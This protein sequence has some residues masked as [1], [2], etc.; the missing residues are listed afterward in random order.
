M[1]TNG[2]RIGKEQRT[3]SQYYEYL[4][5]GGMKRLFENAKRAIAFVHVQSDSNS[6]DFPE[7]VPRRDICCCKLRARNMK[8]QV[9]SRHSGCPFFIYRCVAI[10]MLFMLLVMPTAYSANSEQESTNSSSSDSSSVSARP[11]IILLNNRTS[12]HTLSNGNAFSSTKKKK[13]EDHHQE[14][15][16]PPS[17]PINVQTKRNRQ[18]LTATSRSGTFSSAQGVS[19]NRN[20]LI[21]IDSILHRQ[22]REKA[23]QDSLESIKM[24]ILMRLNLKKLPNITKPISVPQNILEDFYKGYNA[25]ITNTIWRR[26]ESTGEPLSPAVLKKDEQNTNK[27][28]DLAGESDMSLSSQMQGDDA[29][30][31]NQFKL[32]YNPGKGIQAHPN[33]KQDFL[34][35]N[36]DDEYDSILSHISSIYVFPEQL[37][38][39]VRHN[40]KT[41]VLRFKFDNSYSDISYATL[42]LYLRGWDWISTHQP[43]LIEEIENQQSKDIVVAIHRAV[44]RANNTSFTHKAKMFEFR[45][46]I[47]SGQGQ[48]VNVDLKP[49]FG[50]RGSNKSHEILIKG[51]ESWM[52]PLVV[53]TDNTSNNPLTVHIEIGS[54]KKHR[55]KRSV[56][57]DCTESDHDMRCC[58][59]PLKVNFTSF[60]WHFVV[61]PTSFDAYFCSGDCRV[62]YLEQYPHTHLAAL[63][64]SATP[65]CSPTKMSSLS[66][67]YFDDNHNLV[68]SVIPN[69]SVEG[70]SCS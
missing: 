49:V 52:K 44:R 11:E 70:C 39:H 32:L 27:S 12:T 57:M 4:M 61:A 59:Y 22:L 63:T 13:T 64:T 56:Y 31:L 16:G 9:I 10:A 30:A 3:E 48:W 38:P 2:Y 45:Q 35:D 18:S 46:K 58:R 25:S 20:T 40:R 68:L 62:G 15:P 1:L 24:H 21:N 6:I 41:D 54:Q 5:G 8:R 51:V 29:N 67:L 43:E 26:R 36:I 19:M 55:R 42:H 60:G 53:T 7:I 50:D 65:C 23:K 47:P 66:L 17:N 28:S 37:Q 33:I 69:M 34:M 14:D